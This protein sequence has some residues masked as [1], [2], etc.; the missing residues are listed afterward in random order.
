[1]SKERGR[2]QGGRK[3]YMRAGLVMRG[4]QKGYARAS[5]V[6]GKVGCWISTILFFTRG[7]LRPS[8]KYLAIY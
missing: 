8:T 1:M 2:E 5:A 7:L 6:F 4:R 3:A